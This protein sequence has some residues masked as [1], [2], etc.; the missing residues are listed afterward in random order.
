MTW[1]YTCYLSS[2][3]EHSRAAE[4]KTSDDIRPMLGCR[5][6]SKAGDLSS[7]RYLNHINSKK[8]CDDSSVSSASPQSSQQLEEHNKQHDFCYSE[9][10][11]QDGCSSCA[12]VGWIF[13]IFF[14]ELL[15]F[16][17]SSSETASPYSKGY[18]HCFWYGKIWS[19]HTLHN[20]RHKL[21][22]TCPWWALFSGL[23]ICWQ[24]SVSTI[25][26][27]SICYLR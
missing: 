13:F 8:Y 5:A 15:I 26:Q 2:L 25:E 24:H 19:V 4:N 22:L 6:V 10:I 1:N 18:S 17:R 9:V 7:Q 3:P 27:F 16:A 20:R 23:L 21:H 12:P 11:A 14:L